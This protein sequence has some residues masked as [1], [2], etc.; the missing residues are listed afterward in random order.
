MA[1]FQ[2]MSFQKLGLLIIDEEHRFGVAH[3]ERLKSLRKQVDVLSLSATP[4]PRTLNMAMGGIRD[5][6]LIA[7]PPAE[8]LSVKTFVGEWNDVVIREACLREIKRGGQVYFVHNRVEDIGRIGE[9]IAKL[10]PEA[11]LRVGHGQMPERELEQVMLDF[12]HRRFNVLLC[13]TIVESGIDV[14][15]ANTIIINRADR[16]GL[17]QLHQLRGRVGRGAHA[18]YCVL[19]YATPLGETSRRRLGAIRE[20]KQKFG[21][22]LNDVALSCVAGGVRTHLAAHEVPLDDIDFRLPRFHIE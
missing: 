19:L 8:R 18:S 14:P 11:T 21:G 5:M 20:V 16:F 7:T 3:K 10:V 6:S 9:R 4:I 1:I 2:D 13:T 17:A 22:T 12:Y 15:T